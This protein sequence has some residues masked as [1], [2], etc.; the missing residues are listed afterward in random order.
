M[1]EGN[2]EENPRLNIC[3]ERERWYTHGKFGPQRK[4]NKMCFKNTIFKKLF[5]NY[6]WKC[7]WKG[8]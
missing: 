3:T 7:R 6:M 5:F 4:Y 1:C 2:N 8:Q